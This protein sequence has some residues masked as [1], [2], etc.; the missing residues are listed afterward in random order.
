MSIS[1]STLKRLWGYVPYTSRPR[2]TTLNILSRYV[3]YRD[4]SAFCE[5]LQEEDIKPENLLITH[6]GNQLK[7]IDFSLA[8]EEA[9]RYRKGGRGT[10]HYAAPELWEEG[11]ATFVSAID[12][13]GKVMQ[14]LRS[15]KGTGFCRTGFPFVLFYCRRVWGIFQGGRSPE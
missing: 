6:K 15:I 7:I 11:K 1:L 13:V 8:D 5:A 2:L 14:E 4:F 9:Y 12:S 10:A 3:G